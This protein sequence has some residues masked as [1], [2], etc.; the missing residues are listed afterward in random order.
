MDTLNVVAATATS[1][2]IIFWFFEKWYAPYTRLLQSSPSY[3]EILK[4][5]DWLLA[6]AGAGAYIVLT[7]DQRNNL[8]L[9]DSLHGLAV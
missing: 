5:L 1:I 4:W 8:P 6:S 3:P 7:I 2:G 9:A